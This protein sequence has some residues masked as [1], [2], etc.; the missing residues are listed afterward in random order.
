MKRIVIIMVML[1]LLPSCTFVAKQK[2]VKTLNK[3][4]SVGFSNSFYFNYPKNGLEKTY[5]TKYY[6]SSE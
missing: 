3:T 5:F 4:E 2:D 1:A 6:H